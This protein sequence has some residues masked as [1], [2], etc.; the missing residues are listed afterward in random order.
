MAIDIKSLYMYLVLVIL[1]LC[2]CTTIPH[3][4]L[5]YKIIHKQLI[6]QSYRNHGLQT[7][8]ALLYCLIFVD[9]V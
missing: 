7:F 2:P 9:F 3:D 4:Q 6:Y 1:N 5:C 8:S